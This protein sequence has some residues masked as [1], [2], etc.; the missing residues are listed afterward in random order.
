[1]SRRKRILVSSC[2]RRNIVVY[3]ATMA[4]AERRVG[5]GA[6]LRV[7]RLSRYFQ[8]PAAVVRFRFCTP[9]NLHFRFS[10]KS[11]QMTASCS[12]SDA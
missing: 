8:Y 6:S 10:I 7:Q 9:G 5:D 2:V 3:D 4:R 11:R 12:L 1:M